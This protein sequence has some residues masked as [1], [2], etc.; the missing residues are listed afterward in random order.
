M[1]RSVPAKIKAAGY[2]ACVCLWAL[3]LQVLG[4]CKGLRKF[5]AA[6]PFCTDRR[7]PCSAVESLLA[8][9]YTDVWE[10]LA[11]FRVR[12]NFSVLGLETLYPSGTSP[13]TVEGAAAE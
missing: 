10:R 6:G 9:K 13:C 3:W 1:V 7:W 4:A 11:E 2:A 8:Q 12:G 5:Q